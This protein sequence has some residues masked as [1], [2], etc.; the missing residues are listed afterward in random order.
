MDLG[1]HPGGRFAAYMVEWRRKVERVGNLNYP[2]EAARL[3]LSGNLLLE[4]ALNPDGT[5]ADIELRRSSG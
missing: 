2:D 4:V 5:V 1:A 3:G